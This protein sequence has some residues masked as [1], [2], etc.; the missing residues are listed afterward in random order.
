[1]HSADTRAQ[2]KKYS[3]SFYRFH[4]L[5]TESSQD[6]DVMLTLPCFVI[7]KQ[8]ASK[9]KILPFLNIKNS[10]FSGSSLVFVARKLA[11]PSTATKICAWRIDGVVVFAPLQTVTKE[12]PPTQPKARS[13]AKV[14]DVGQRRFSNAM[15]HSL[16]WFFIGN[17]GLIRTTEGFLTLLGRRY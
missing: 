6:E 17:T 1:L 14:A 16:I 12:R 8:I 15:K 3:I 5:K 2:H 4:I 11:A 7:K 9:A 13:K 10:F